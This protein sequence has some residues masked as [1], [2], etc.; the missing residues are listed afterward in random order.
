MLVTAVVVACRNAVN[1][2]RA[3][4]SPDLG[5]GFFYVSLPLVGLVLA[6]SGAL[7]A[8]KRPFFG[9]RHLGRGPL[10]WGLC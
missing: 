10:V 9:N 3:E 2:C 1:D 5:L 6:S 8:A 7:A 4:K